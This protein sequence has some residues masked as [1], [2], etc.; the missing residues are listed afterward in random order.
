MGRVRV[1]GYFSFDRIEAAG[2]VHRDV[3]GGAALYAALA[4][5]AQGADVTLAAVAGSDWPQAWLESLSA[6]GIDV[7]AV[8]RGAEPTRR[9]RFAG[10]QDGPRANP[11]HD[12]PEWWART[13]ELAPVAP[14]DFAPSDVVAAMPVPARVAEELLARARASGARVTLDASAAFARAE[15][16]AYRA[17][18]PHIDAFCAGPEETRVL[19][20][21]LDDDAAVLALARLGP[22]VLHKRG[23]AGALAVAAGGGEVRVLPAPPAEM[24]ETTGAGDATTGALAACLAAGMPFFAAAERA[25]TAGARCVTGIGPAAFDFPPLGSR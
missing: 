3:P 2:H 19:F 4:A 21:G 5:R 12:D 8:T 23:S 7:S 14:T 18:M 6:R 24:R 25:L 22:A 13:A 1:V 17:L 10:T 20:P 11:H 16:N 9:A 15:G